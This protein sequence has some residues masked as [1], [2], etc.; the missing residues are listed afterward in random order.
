[1]ATM[2]S[3]DETIEP[4]ELIGRARALRPVLRDRQ[5]TTERNRRIS[6]ES[7]ADIRKAGLFRALQPTHHGGL[8]VALDD[9]LQ[10]RGQP[11]VEVQSNTRK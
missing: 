10:A 6:D 1:M 5:E 3:G 4:T 9:L 8:E 7:I 11:V 2:A